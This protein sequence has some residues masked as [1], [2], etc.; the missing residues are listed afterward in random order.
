MRVQPYIYL[1]FIVMWSEVVGALEIPCGVDGESCE[2]T[3]ESSET[4]R[5]L[6]PWVDFTPDPFE[7]DES[8]SFEEISIVKNDGIDRSS[9]ESC[10]M[11]VGVEDGDLSRSICQRLIS[12]PE[13]GVYAILLP[14]WT[15]QTAR[16]LELAKVSETPKYKVLNGWDDQPNFRRLVKD[17]GKLALVAGGTLVLFYLLPESIAGWDDDKKNGIGFS[18]WK[19]NVTSPVM[20][21]DHPLINY[22]GHPYFGA[23]YMMLARRAGY[24]EFQAFIYAVVMSS[25]FEVVESF[26]ERISIQDLIVTPV[27]GYIMYKG[28]V[29]LENRIVRNG[30]ELL[31][32]RFLARFVRVMNPINVVDIPVHLANL[33]RRLRREQLVDAYGEQA[34]IDSSW[35][36]KEKMNLGL[37]FITRPEDVLCAVEDE[38]S[39]R[40]AAPG[41]LFQM[42]F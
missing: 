12:N 19:S 22:F 29:H 15:E 27:G 20:D 30:G 16:Q 39:C 11:T 8:N 35:D 4:P 41:V 24:S 26:L 18:R 23:A 5:I 42:D 28:F 32:S 34:V 38:S 14:E 17:S 25:G 9:L 3:E 31:G 37:G 36:Q 1:F 33:Y 40:Q 13:L 7:T 10:Q 21:E 6:L 2:L